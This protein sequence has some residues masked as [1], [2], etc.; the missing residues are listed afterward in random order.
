MELLKI[1]GLKIKTG[2]KVLVDE[3][4][5]SINRGE[6][7]SLV[8]ESGSGKSLTCLSVLNLLP[9]T[10]H[11]E[12]SIKY[13]EQD[14][15]FSELLGMN[16]KQRKQYALCKIAYI[17][18][19]PL[20]ALN[21]VQKCGDQLFENLIL[22]GYK[23]KEELKNKAIELLKS[24]ELNQTDKVL[25][26]YPFQLSGGQRQ[27][28]MIA[29]A[30]AGNPD[31]I[32]ADEPTT[33]LDVIIQEEILELIRSLAK[34]HGKSVLLISHDLDAVGRF[35]DRIAV[36]YKGKIIEQGIASEVFGHP[37]ENYTKALLACKP[38]PDK[39][40]YYLTTIQSEG[41]KPKPFVEPAASNEQMLSVNLLRKE[42]YL[43]DKVFRA[44]KSLS[45]DL[46]K[47]QSVGLIGE[48]GS[49]KST[50][51]K[52]LVNLE[53]ATGGTLEYDFDNKL[54]L[55]SNVQL[56]FQDPFAALNPE[57]NVRSM[58][59]E[60]I[61]KH[62]KNL[63]SSEVLE[64][65]IELLVKVGL[66]P[67]DLVKFPANFSGGQRQRLCIARALAVNPTLLICDESTSA[68]D[69][70]VQA[71]IL[72]LLK[73][74]QISEGLTILMITHSMAVAAWFCQYLIVLKDGY[75]VEQGKTSDLI[76]NA[77][78]E[79]TRSLLQHI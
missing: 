74:L 25:N 71:Q 61:R 21:P 16:S 45:F 23:G 50:I 69:L 33:A 19:E 31:L 51:S 7:I 8:G 67:E 70:S 42:F 5:L 34:V 18:Q 24:V 3:L 47:G 41:E 59:S 39:K 27:R 49:G 44:L 13:F 68:L 76:K 10:L 29:M 64:L 2:D 73:E 60:V 15:S 48:S 32:I 28:V 57:I 4:N 1:E 54:S 30:L 75:I 56:I 55:S 53:S 52:I 58:L 38:T 62:G 22:C 17:F 12:G 35:S 11:P 65:S 78:N 72:N 40:G 66:T 46:Y 20:T 14:G 36:M 9:E 43:D 63:S 79:Y 77:S 37:K 26:A 6:I